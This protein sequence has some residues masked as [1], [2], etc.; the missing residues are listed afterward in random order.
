M[1]FGIQNKN[2][3]QCFLIPHATQYQMSDSDAMHLVKRNC[4]KALTTT[5]SINSSTKTK[6]KS[7]N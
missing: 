7:R 5:T 2:Q 6:S 3:H 4:H 1:I